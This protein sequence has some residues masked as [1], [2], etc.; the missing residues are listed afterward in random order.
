MKVGFLQLRP[1]FGTLRQ[2]LRSAKSLL[3]NVSDATIVLPELF[4]TGYLFRSKD[5][6]KRLA[7]SVAKGDTVAEMK[8]LAKQQ[9]LN[10]IFGMAEKKARKY[11]NSAV[12]ITSAGKVFTYQKTHLFDRE[13]LFFTPGTNGYAVHRIQGVRIGIM[14]CFDW[15][16]P[17]VARVL[18]LKG[19]QV[20]CHPSNLILP[21][22]LDAMRTRSIEN[23]V[24]TI[25]A[26]RI[27]T[28]KRANMSVTFTGNSQVISPTGEVLTSAGDRSESLKIVEIDVE[29]ADNKSIAPNT[30]LF[31]DRKV[32]LYKTLVSKTA[33]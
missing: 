33:R 11:Y 24:F 21:Y 9:N 25:T 20:I 4:N 15:C 13:K 18:A 6:L 29:E 17:E 14:I 10:L 7:E 8:K 26:N 22:G 5:E 12:L 1:K 28:E 2:N 32:G 27:G 16:F 23:R 19:A 3:K 31:K 30:D